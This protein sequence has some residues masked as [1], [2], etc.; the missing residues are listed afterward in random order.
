M[1]NWICRTMK[2]EDQ[3]IN[4]PVKAANAITLQSK[5]ALNNEI[6]RCKMYE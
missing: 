2:N 3:N 5:K 1:N 4:L 6:T